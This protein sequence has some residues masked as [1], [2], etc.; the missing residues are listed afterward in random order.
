MQCSLPDLKTQVDALLRENQ[1]SLDDLGAAPPESIKDCRKRL[2]E[3]AG[4][5]TRDVRDASYFCLYQGV[6]AEQMELRMCARFR[7]A[8]SRFSDSVL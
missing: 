3:S 4:A 8:S 7:K 6:L 5:V 2:R 1:A